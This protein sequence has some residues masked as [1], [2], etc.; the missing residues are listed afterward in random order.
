MCRRQTGIILSKLYNN[1]SNTLSQLNQN[2]FDYLRDIEDKTTRKIHFVK[3][4]P[5]FSKLA[6]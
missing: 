2:L 5:M 6:D 4:I 3:I 1:Y